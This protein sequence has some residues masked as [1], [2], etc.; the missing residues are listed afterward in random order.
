[1]DVLIDVVGKKQ[2]VRSIFEQT[3][4]YK[5]PVILYEEVSTE[6]IHEVFSLY[7]KQGKHLNA[8]EIRNARFHGLALMRGLLATAG[9]SEDVAAVAPFLADQ[10]D[11]LRSTPTTLDNEQYGFGRAG[12]KRTKLFVRTTSN[13]EKV[14]VDPALTISRVYMV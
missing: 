10:W 1:M 13:G 9:D 12:Y 6:Q 5:V 8:E 7:N 3:S 2:R 11:D 14:I 4:S